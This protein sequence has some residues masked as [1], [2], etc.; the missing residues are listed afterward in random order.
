MK[1]IDRVIGKKETKEP[2]K[3]TPKEYH[4]ELAKECAGGM[5]NQHV[6][7]AYLLDRANA[8]QITV[9][10]GD[11]DERHLQF[12]R[13]VVGRVKE[14]PSPENES[15]LKRRFAERDAHIASSIPAD[16]SSIVIL[17][18]AHIEGVKENL[19]KPQPAPKISPLIKEIEMQTNPKA[20]ADRSVLVI[21]MRG[22]AEPYIAKDNVTQA[23]AV[24][25]DNLP[26]KLSIS[27]THDFSPYSPQQ[28][29]IF[30]KQ[31]ANAAGSSPS[32]ARPNTQA[33]EAGKMQR[34]LERAQQT[35]SDS[36]YVSDLDVRT[37]KITPPRFERS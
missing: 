13:N 25:L 6:Y 8:H 3:L 2:A 19:E 21:D 24:F 28:I 32:H 5:S 20:V 4:L 10:P 34:A 27:S 22:L 16:T 9:V 35:P 31:A 29:G 18:A 26:G 33:T 12:F 11:V 14:D 23:K 15:L 1:F 36:N 30:A 17:G 37:R 7:R